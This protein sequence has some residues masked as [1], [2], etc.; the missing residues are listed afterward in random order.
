MSDWYWC[1]V[2]T[3]AGTVPLRINV[4]IL[5][6]CISVYRMQSN[7]FSYMLYTIV[8]DVTVIYYIYRVLS[9]IRVIF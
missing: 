8:Y 7:H 2:G 9:Q 5:F 6:S 4:V 1:F 3:S